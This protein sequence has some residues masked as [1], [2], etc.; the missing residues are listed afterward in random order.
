[1]SAKPRGN[2]PSHQVKTFARRHEKAALPHQESDFAFFWQY[3]LCGSFLRFHGIPPLHQFPSLKRPEAPIMRLV[4]K[5][6]GEATKGLSVISAHWVSFVVEQCTLI[7]YHVSLSETSILYYYKILSISL[8][9]L[10][11]GQAQ[12]FRSTPNKKQ[13]LHSPS[14]SSVSKSDGCRSASM[15]FCSSRCSS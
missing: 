12:E 6:P 11:N 8:L 9:I 3:A 15:R 14:S 1:M 5:I 4:G 10:W 13:C 2:L 7:P